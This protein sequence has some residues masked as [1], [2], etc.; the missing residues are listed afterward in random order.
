M[1]LWRLTRSEELE[2]ETLQNLAWDR[3]SHLNN[4]HTYTHM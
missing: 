3:T 2:G 4:C 1:P